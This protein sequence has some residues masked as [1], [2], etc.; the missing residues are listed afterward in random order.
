MANPLID[1]GTLQR[2][3]GSVTWSSN[4]TLNITAPYLGKEALHLAIQGEST[5]YIPTMTG[6]V[7]SQEPYMMIELTAHLLKT[8]PLSDLYKQRM[9]TDSFLGDGT[10]RTDA[11]SLGSYQI[12]NC[13]VSGVRELSFAGEDAGYILMVKGYYLVNSTL[14]S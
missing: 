1:Q 8:Q 12:I 10:V 13:S 7:R 9:E 2:V 6:A 4:P 14:F 3:R 11:Q 5:T